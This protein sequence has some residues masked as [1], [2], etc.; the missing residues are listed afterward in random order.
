MILQTFRT[1]FPHATLW[2]T[3][4]YSVMLATPKRLSIDLRRLDARLD[5]ETVRTRLGE[6]DL[7]EP[8]A[9]LA[10]LALDEDGV[11]AYVGPGRIN[12]DD[13]PEVSLGD[14]GRAGTG[15]GLSALLGIVPHL[16]DD[17]DDLLTGAT[18]VERERLSRRLAAR[19]RAWVATIALRLGRVE[20]ARHD[21]RLA[22]EA[23]PN[24]AMA[25][26]LV[27]GLER[28]EPTEP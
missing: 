13:Q 22:L 25:R 2:M 12:T 28:G 24:E 3:P 17:A 16:I 11:G 5:D 9:F 1:V 23:D 27:D 6:V 21:L 10:A 8:L 19:K 26:R 14:R 20:R 4:G 15:G 18:A 7:G